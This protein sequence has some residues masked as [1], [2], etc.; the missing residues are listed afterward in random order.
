MIDLDFKYKNLLKFL[1]KNSPFK[2][3]LALVLGSGLGD[4][5][6][7][8]ELTKSISTINLPSYPASTVVGHNGKIIFGQYR[9]KKLLLFQGRIHFYEGYLLSECILPALITYKSGCKKIILTNAAGG[10]NCEFHPGNLMLA[11][12]FNGIYIKKEVTDLLG[13]SGIRKK[14][15]FFKFPVIRT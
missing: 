11:D 2:P 8:I 13:L 12:S 9:G 6:E 5:A 10:V 14:R 7:G 1:E 3:D 4:F 15:Q